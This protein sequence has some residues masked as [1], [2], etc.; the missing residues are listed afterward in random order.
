MS[1]CPKGTVNICGIKHERMKEAIA[2]KPS[3]GCWGG[4]R[5][6]PMDGPG[7]L[8]DGSWLPLEEMARRWT[9]RVQHATAVSP[10]LGQG[11]KEQHRTGASN[12]RVRV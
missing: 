12:A 1:V 9:W 11:P 7:L 4:G 3:Q 10:D 5:W 2:G 6:K 8:S